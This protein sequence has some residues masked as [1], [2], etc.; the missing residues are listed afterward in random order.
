LERDRLLL[1]FD[2]P[3]I[4]K[5]S[6]HVTSKEDTKQIVAFLKNYCQSG[7]I[8]TQERMNNPLICRL[9]IS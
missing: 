7:E 2:P 9:V 6:P 4:D 1:T 5:D 8:P 3:Q